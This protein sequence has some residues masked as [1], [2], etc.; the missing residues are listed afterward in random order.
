MRHASQ[1]EALLTVYCLLVSVVCINCLSSTSA[2]RGQ[3]REFFIPPSPCLMGPS[4]RNCVETKTFYSYQV[5]CYHCRLDNLVILG[6]L[7]HCV[8][9]RLPDSSVDIGG[10]CSSGQIC[11]NCAVTI[12]EP[13]PGVDSLCCQDCGL[14]LPFLHRNDQGCHCVGDTQ[15]RAHQAA[16]RFDPEKDTST[17]SEF[18]GSGGVTTMFIPLYLLLCTVTLSLLTIISSSL[19]I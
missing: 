5:C 19:D 7:C 15:G 14:V 4:C 8:D 13:T 12:S 17:T 18:Y 2:V 10:N 1:S 6:D 11:D 16:P 9:T 3:R